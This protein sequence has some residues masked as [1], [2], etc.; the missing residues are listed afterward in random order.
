M[1][2]WGSFGRTVSLFQ[3]TVNLKTSKGKGGYRGRYNTSNRCRTARGKKLRSG[4]GF[5]PEVEKVPK[6]KSA[7]GP[8][9]A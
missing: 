2:A 8:E 1:A 6:R 5:Y 7:P 3:F 9:G 4:K